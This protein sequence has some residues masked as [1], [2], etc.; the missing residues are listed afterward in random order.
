VTY[1][2]PTGALFDAGGGYMF[3]PMLGA[4][5]TVGGAWFA[6]PATGDASI[7]HPLFWFDPNQN[8]EASS[9]VNLDSS[10]T[11]V[12]LQVIARFGTRTLDVRA[13]G[14]PGTGWAIT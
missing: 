6:S 13:F 12:H 9:T 4:G 2:Q 5:V 11:A 3:T 7:P 8:L 10:E 1:G 14:G